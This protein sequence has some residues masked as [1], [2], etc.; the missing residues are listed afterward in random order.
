MVLFLDFQK[1]PAP[2]SKFG[3]SSNLSLRQ[4]DQMKAKKSLILANFWTKFRPIWS[5]WF[6]A[7]G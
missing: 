3:P 5:H 4:Y 2:Q 7:T 1:D 6:D